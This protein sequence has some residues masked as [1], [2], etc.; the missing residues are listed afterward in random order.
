MAKKNREADSQNTSDTT[1]NAFNKGMVKDY[2]NSFMPE[3]TWNHA[4]NLVNNSKT[5]DVGVVGNEPA[6]VLCTNA[7][8]TVIGSI[9][10][11][12]DYF[13]IFSTDDT[14]SEIGLFFQPTSTYTAIVN[15]PCL[16]FNR[17]N[18]IIGDSKYK[19]DC[20][21]DL[22][23][24]DG[25]NPSR[26]LNI[27]DLNEPYPNIFN[28]EPWPGVPYVCDLTNTSP[29]DPNSNCVTCEPLI[30]LQLNCDKIRLEKHMTIPCVSVTRGLA[31][32]QLLNGSYFAVIAYSEN[33]QKVTDYFN[34][35]EIQAL[36]VH[37]NGGSSL[38]ITFS[39]LDTEN[40][41]EFQL[42][43]VSTTNQQTV[44]KE[45]GYYSTRTKS[46][47]KSYFTYSCT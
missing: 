27:G 26:K 15:D 2:D 42:V 39:N 13:I 34:P 18:L 47:S 31:G 19:F 28:N 7:P 37:R 9:P 14:N 22:Y 16:A 12:Q 17:E 3:G 35:S 38:D 46:L 10:L 23:W 44:A 41:D 5:G 6:N 30:P 1:T 32:G 11:I 45:I 43:V 8:Y 29:N 21:Y 40:F 24:D 36:F 33:Q 25:L 20:T 4:R